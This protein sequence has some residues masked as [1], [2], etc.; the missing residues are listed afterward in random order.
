[1]LRWFFESSWCCFVLVLIA[2]HIDFRLGEDYRRHE[3]PKP[4][5]LERISRVANR[6]KDRC[7]TAKEGILSAPQTGALTAACRQASRFLRIA[8][9]RASPFDRLAAGWKLRRGLC[10]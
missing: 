1:M 3:N 8:A 5:G 4:R 7:K 10:G 2:V 9:Q 6:L